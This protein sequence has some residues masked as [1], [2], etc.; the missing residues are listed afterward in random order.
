MSE[1][2]RLERRIDYLSTQVERLIDMHQ[3]HPSRMREFRKAAML[4]GQ[5]FEQ[6]VHARKVLAYVAQLPSERPADV[7]GGVLPL[8]ESTQR[9]L[10]DVANATQIDEQDVHKILATVVGG[11][12]GGARQLF[13]AWK[14]DAERSEQDA[15]KKAS[16]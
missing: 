3:P 7:S 11:G 13:D 15:E 8:P 2:E 5:T 16:E 9:M 10:E 14:T 4:S 6:E 1:L 12:I